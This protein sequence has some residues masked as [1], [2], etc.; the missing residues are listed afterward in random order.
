V[1]EIDE[2]AEESEVPEGS[3]VFPEIP[4]DLHVS[5]QLLAIMHA[6]VFIAGSDNK[7]VNSA[8]GDEALATM[9]GYLERLGG[10]DRKRIKDDLKALRD[11]AK[12][13]GWP[14]QY[15]T[16]LKDFPKDFGLVDE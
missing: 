13:Q 6:I 4:L 2:E 8:A 7:I 16:F 12:Q 15:T 9:A 3:A 11:Y 14:K 1:A 5:P 10:P